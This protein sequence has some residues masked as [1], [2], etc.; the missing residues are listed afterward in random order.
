MKTVLITGAAGY[1]GSHLAKTFKQ[2][3]WKVVG[4]GHKRHTMNQYIDVMHY[5]DIRDRELLESLFQH[6]KFDLVC[7]TLIVGSG[8]FFL[9]WIYRGNANIRIVIDGYYRRKQSYFLTILYL[10]RIN[11]FKT[12]LIL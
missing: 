9:G 3:G 1:L 2:A 12:M 11:T 5:G 10:N 4:F 8:N 6:I 7:F